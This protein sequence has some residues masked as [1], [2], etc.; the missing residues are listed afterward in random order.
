VA[1]YSTDAIPDYEPLSSTQRQITVL[2]ELKQLTRIKNYEAS[3]YAN[4][5]RFIYSRF[6]V[7]YT[8]SIDMTRGTQFFFSKIQEPSI[9]SRRQHDDTNQ[10]PHSEPGK[11]IFCATVN[12]I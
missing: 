9:Y 7:T 5:F 4:F 6:Y 12:K 3:R 1:S 11:N 8:V 2:A 10:V